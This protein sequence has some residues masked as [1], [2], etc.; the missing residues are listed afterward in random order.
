MALV[1]G[2]TLGRYRL[3]REL[4]DGGMA[5]VWEAKD[6]GL[7]R[8]VAIKVMRTS[9]AQ[10]PEEEEHFLD[11]FLREA[12]TIAR[13]EHPHIVQVFELGQHEG[14]AFLAMRLLKGGTLSKRIARPLPPQQAAAWLLNL[15]AALDYAN[16]R[17]VIHRDIK[18][19][20]VLF[21][22][23]ETIFLADFGIAKVIDASRELTET[24]VIL[25]TL[26]Y[27]SPEQVNAGLLDGR[28]D[29]YSLAVLAYKMLTGRTPFAGDSTG[30]LLHQIL[31]MDPPLASTVNRSLSGRVDP[32]LGR[33]LAKTRE[34][35][36]ESSSAFA[37]ALADALIT[38]TA[39]DEDSQI[40]TQAGA[41]GHPSHGSGEPPASLEIAS[42]AVRL[43]GATGLRRHVVLITAAFASALAL[44]VLSWY[45]LQPSPIGKDQS[46]VADARR[47]SPI[48]T[49]A[50][51][52]RTEG[53]LLASA[54]IAA[55][56]PTVEPTGVAL[57]PPGILRTALP[58]APP[59]PTSR[60]EGTLVIRSSPRPSTYTATAAPRT[61]GPVSSGGESPASLESSAPPIG[62]AVPERA[63]KKVRTDFG[64][65][66]ERVRNLDYV[67]AP[68]DVLDIRVLEAE[69]LDAEVRVE[70]T[71]AIWLRLIGELH[72]AGLSVAD[73]QDRVSALLTAK[74]FNRAT[75]LVLVKGYPRRVPTPVAIPTPGGPQSQTSVTSGAVPA[76]E[77]TLSADAIVKK[78]SRQPPGPERRLLAER[79]ARLYPKSVDLNLG[80][81]WESEQIGDHKAAVKWATQVLAVEPHNEDALVLRGHALTALGECTQALTDFAAIPTSRS[82]TVAVDRFLCLVRQKDW[83]AAPEVLGKLS[84]DERDRADVTVAIKKLRP[85]SPTITPREVPTA[86]AI[87]TPEAGFSEEV[88]MARRLVSEGHAQDAEKLLL[89]ALRRGAPPRELR[90][91][92]LEAACLAKD[93]RV[94]VAQIPLVEPFGEGEEAWMFYAAVVEF[95]TGAIEKSRTLMSRARPKIIPS[96]Y[97]DFYLKKIL[98][99]L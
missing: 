50:R 60:P 28:S 62:T 69:E 97:V 21:D 29:Q 91:G 84:K 32:I 99:P 11:R 1:E 54:T 2:M 31:H 17:G 47:P 64:V 18:P 92:L 70:G 53:T 98:G 59:V 15:A 6:E 65:V 88:S 36:F 85:V 16:R 42:T 20:N 4:G 38:A 66:G 34:A 55:P 27:M 9:G 10:T 48:G 86:T 87:A 77:A 45:A 22:D 72:V 23:D 67:I 83:V 3:V 71:G 93:W 49:R 33:A 95:E 81:A 96:P 75:V 73:V 94:A 37:R 52:D 43:G 80:I 24:G 51:S 63:T 78:L 14:K 13:L 61:T 12:R 40:S 30:V 56:R 26:S 46:V 35:R 25:G 5:V 76:P 44:V 19:A 41:L 90:K 82:D 39:E 7:G 74:Y 89:A 68:N 8:S 79:Y 58:T 57:L